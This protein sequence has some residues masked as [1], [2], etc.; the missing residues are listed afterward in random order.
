[1]HL[2]PETFTNGP[3]LTDSKKKR[4]KKKKKKHPLITELAFFTFVYRATW[5]SL[6]TAMPC[7]PGGPC[8]P[9]AC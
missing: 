2:S 9:G 1:M 4:K 8:Q 6:L 3:R 5:K 7:P